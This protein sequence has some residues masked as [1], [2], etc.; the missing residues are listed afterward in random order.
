MTVTV[1]V[2]N[3]DDGEAGEGDTVGSDIE[4]V[5]GGQGDDN[6]DRRASARRSSTAAAATTRSTAAPAQAT[7]STAATAPTR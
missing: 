7:C 5:R 4:I 6:L 1:G 2:T 3:A